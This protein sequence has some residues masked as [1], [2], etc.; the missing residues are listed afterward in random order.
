[1]NNYSIKTNKNTKKSEKQVKIFEF[2]PQDIT[3]KDDSYHGSLGLQFTEWWYFD[4]LL[5][6]GYSIQFSIR[7][8]SGFKLSF[9]FV[10][11]DIYKEGHLVV[12]KR[13]IH[14]LKD[15][16]ISREKPFIKISQRTIM[17]GYLD[18]KRGTFIYDISL[19]MDDITAQLQF[20]GIT[21]G[22]KGKHEAN[23]WW[24]VALPRAQV[25]GMITR[26]QQSI[27]VYGS[28]YHDHNW[29]VKIFALKNIGWYWGKIYS[30]HTAIT[31]AK[32]LRTTVKTQSL[33]I[34]NTVDNGYIN[35]SPMNFKITA[36]DIYEENR[37]MIPHIFNLDAKTDKVTLHVTMKCI[38]IHHVKIFPLMDYWRYHMKC[39]GSVTI[40]SETESINE[41]YITEFLKFR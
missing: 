36:T 12:H 8:L 33:L 7:I 39:N 20:I 9:L 27:D 38:D 19:V 40:N 17:N 31:W 18:E 35:I 15:V 16:E 3:L 32:I 5:N 28:G 34:I 13:K 1:M 11:F 10:R 25:K 6:D 4:A 2:Q 41:I 37:K 26:R 29:N 23:D 22:W 24:A 30:D 21:Q 14:L